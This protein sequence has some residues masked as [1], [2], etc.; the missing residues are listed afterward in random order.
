MACKHYKK[1]SCGG[2]S[3]TNTGL[4]ATKT[5]PYVKDGKFLDKKA[6]EACRGYA[7]AEV[8][9][10]GI[11]GVYRPGC[12]HKEGEHYVKAI[13]EGDNIV[14]RMVDHCGIDESGGR[15]LLINK[16]TGKVGLKGAINSKYNFDLGCNGELKTTRNC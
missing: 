5:C 6:R 2:K 4:T 10:K 1:I 7:K 13:D 16:K 12:T 3:C 9:K 14:I 15:L 8:Q 11:A